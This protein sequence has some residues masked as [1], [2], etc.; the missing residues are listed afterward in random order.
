MANYQLY[1]RILRLSHLD[2]HVSMAIDGP[3]LRVIVA[4]VIYSDR[5]LV[6][7]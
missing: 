4:E 3:K 5:T 6:W 1:A 7:C 2:H